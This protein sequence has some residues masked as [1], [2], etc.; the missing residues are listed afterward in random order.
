MRKLK[1]VIVIG[2]LLSLML[3]PAGAAYASSPGSAGD[4]LV[5][6]SWVDS[7]VEDQFASLQA[8]INQLKL[9]VLEKLGGNVNIQLYIGD[10]TAYVNGAAILIDSDRPAVVPQLKTDKK[11]GGYTMVPV[12]FVAESMGL[13]VEWLASTRQV[14]F[15]DA[16]RQIV[17]NIDNRAATINGEDYTMGYAPFIENQR[18]YVHVRFVAEAFNCQVGWNQG[19][20]RVDITR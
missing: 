15:S 2:L 16:S 1:G 18:T 7:Y 6:K 14:V 8:Q 11:G 9:L 19:D 20:K 12:R 3:M 13:D 4:P 17:L 5:S 10:S